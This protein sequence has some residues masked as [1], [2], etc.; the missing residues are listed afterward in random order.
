VIDF[1]IPGKPCAW[2]RARSNGKVRF[3]SPEQTRNKL[4]VAT[5][6][7]NAMQGQPPLEGPLYVNI[8]ATWPWP[9]SMSLK[10]RAAHHGYYTA[11][12]DADNIAK[13]LGD[14]LN[15]I[16][17]RDDSQIIF[18]NVSKVYGDVPHTYVHVERMEEMN[19]R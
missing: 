16:V 17:W 14:A 15:N 7:S 18:L 12:P 3:D 1:K 9:K 5:I 2:Q 19:E 6:G 10:K 8:V 11:R 13:L 4:T